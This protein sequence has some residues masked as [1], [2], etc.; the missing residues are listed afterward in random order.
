MYYLCY[1]ILFQKLSREQK[2][3]LIKPDYKL[4]P[5]GKK[6]RDFI[7]PLGDLEKN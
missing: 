3:L 4:F 5:K 7:K 1:V 2:D 6:L